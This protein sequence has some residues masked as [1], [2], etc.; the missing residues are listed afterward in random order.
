MI[1]LVPHIYI[2][3]NPASGLQELLS[4]IDY[5]SLVLITDTNTIKDCFPKIGKLTGDVLHITIP[6]GEEHK[7]ITTCEQVW[8]EMTQANVDRKALVVNLGGGVVGDLGGFCAATYK[9]GIKF[10]NIPTTLLAQ[11]DASI[12]GKQGIDFKHF[13]NQIGVFQNPEAVL[14]YA[15]FLE[16][17]SRRELISGYAEVV[18]HALISD[19]KLWQDIKNYPIAVDKLEKIIPAAVKI[20]YQ[21]VKEDPFESGKRKILNFGHTLGHALESYL[22]GKEERKILHG[23]AVAA[24]IVMESWLSWQLSF[25]SEEEYN[26]ITQVIIDIFP[27]IQYYLEEIY[28]ITTYLQQDKK[29]E[30]GNLKFSLLEGIG[31]GIYDINVELEECQ[32][33]L[34]YYCNR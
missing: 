33:A 27:D 7:N 14:I 15:G 6:A 16:T 21:V 28:N 32:K 12:G 17:L 23:E 3:D 8:E 18:K 22:L 29:N 13:K 24:G 5:S 4:D 34:E 25:I 11:V 1:E 30:K 31:Q 19:K 2:T 26:E 20:K 10:L 9:R